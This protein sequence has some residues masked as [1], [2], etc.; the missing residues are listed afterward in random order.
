MDQEVVVKE[1]LSG[2]MIDA[3][4]A[5]IRQLDNDAWPVMGAF[6]YYLSDANRWRLFVASPKVG[7]EGPQDAYKQIHAALNRLGP[8]SAQLT[9]HDITAIDPSNPMVALFRMLVH[10]GQGGIAGFRFSG[11][12][13]NGRVIED[14]YVYRMA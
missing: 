4:A 1:A 13:V 7:E 12:V 3:G 10:T 9:L 2:G 8:S 11:N 14:A 6:W 5:L